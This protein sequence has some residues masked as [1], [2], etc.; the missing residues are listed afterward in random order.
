MEVRDVVT[1]VHLY[2]KT[3]KLSSPARTH[4]FEISETNETNNVSFKKTCSAMTDKFLKFMD[5]LCR[6]GT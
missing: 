6:E 1:Q 2:A 5:S 4:G 3:A